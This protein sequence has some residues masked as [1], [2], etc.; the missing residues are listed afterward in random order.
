MAR[1]VI[2]T[3]DANGATKIEAQGYEGGTCMEATA[4][5]ENM[6]KTTVKERVMEGECG[7]RPDM[8]EYA[9]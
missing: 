9:R 2:M 8:G 7:P 6:F 3:V 5:F 4:P 1:K